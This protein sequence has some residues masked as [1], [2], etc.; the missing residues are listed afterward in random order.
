MLVEAATRKFWVH[1]LPLPR[2]DLLL[3][4]DCF[5]STD[6]T[7]ECSVKAGTVLAALHFGL[8]IFRQL[9]VSCSAELW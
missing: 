9:A 1:V 2:L 5:C 4:P 8:L 7:Q 6:S 3:S